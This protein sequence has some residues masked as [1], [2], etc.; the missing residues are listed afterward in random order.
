MT[1]PY[2][3]A[4]DGVARRVAGVGYLIL[5]LATALPVLDYFLS[6]APFHPGVTSWRFG[7]TG[8][9]ATY[10]MGTVVE[11]FLVM[12]LALAANHRR[13][14]TFV[15]VLA[16]IL[17]V[18]MLGAGLFFILD[19]LQTR[20]LV[21]PVS[22]RRFDV[23]AVEAMLKLFSFG[24]AAAWLCRVGLRRSARDEIGRGRVSSQ[25]IPIIGRQPLPERKVETAL[26]AE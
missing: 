2:S 6:I 12:V 25:N 18:F 11:L 20:S 8:V 24:I 15:G 13:V 22:M 4:A 21:S 9:L 16:G 7:A 23:A 1:A 3:P 19:T 26:P 10:S 17:A 14:V 5:G